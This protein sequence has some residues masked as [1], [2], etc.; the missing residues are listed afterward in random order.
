[1]RLE[2]SG[3]RRFPLGLGNSG[4]D[5][6]FPLSLAIGPRG[7][8]VSPESASGSENASGFDATSHAAGEGLETDRRAE[9][10]DRFCPGWQ[11]L[12]RL[13][14]DWRLGRQRDP[15]DSPGAS[16]GTSHP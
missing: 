14:Q 2:Q 10:Q 16:Q 11:T 12:A 3:D 8:S 1:M 4:G 9:R 7:T 13:D 5:R 6:H 15:F